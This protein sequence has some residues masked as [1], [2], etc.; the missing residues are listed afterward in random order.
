MKLGNIKL[1]FIHSNQ[2]ED[3]LV[4]TLFHG[5][6]ELLGHNCVD[7]PRY[8][9]MYKPLTPGIKAKLRGN[10]F[11]IYGLLEE[12]PELAEKRFFWRKDLEQYDLIIIAHLREQWQ[13]VWELAG[14]VEPEKI[15]IIDGY[16]TPAFFPY[17][18]L[19]WRL[20]SC[21]WTYFTPL[22]QSK[23]FKRELISEGACYSLDR[24]LP[25]PLRQ[26]IPLPKN[27]YPISFS[28]PQEKIWRGDNAEKMKD[29][30]THIV[31]KEVAS[32]VQQSFFSATGS[33][34]YIFTSETE[35]YQD[36]RKSR[37]GITT[38]RAGWDC[39]RHYELAANGCVLCFKDLDFKPPT[40][41]PQGLDESNCIIYHNYD[42]LK[43]KIAALS[44][45]D[46]KRLQKASYQW[47][48]NNTTL[49]RAQEFL[50]T[51][52]PNKKI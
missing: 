42:E 1:L 14:K 23:Y 2:P 45:N 26:W 46:Y 12:S 36:L 18:S 13:L 15:V 9:G 3:Y 22:S 48:E 30:P 52:L 4:D 51:C 7:I 47:I 10:G 43:A 32:K 20:K 19:G 11:T 37:F 24:F 16:D 40:C 6:R 50:K 39:L 38:K 17:V 25:R 49:V 21:P 33:D 5:L 35:Y 41:A 34:K 28:L 8:D 29:F 44:D 31:D 27:A